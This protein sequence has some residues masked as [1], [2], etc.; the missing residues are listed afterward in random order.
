MD[1]D[2]PVYATIIMLSGGDYNEKN[3][4]IYEYIPDNVYKYTT[5]YKAWKRRGVAVGLGN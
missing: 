5:K 2:A 3:V 1:A 4:K